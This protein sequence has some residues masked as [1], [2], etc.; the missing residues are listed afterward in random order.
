MTREEALAE[1]R[2][3]IGRAKVLAGHAENAAHNNDLR[4]KAPG[5]AA[6]GAAWADVARSYTAIAAVLPEP[7]PEP[8]SDNETPEV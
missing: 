1:A 6:A 5:F 7:K 8:T 4:H 2:T 3:A